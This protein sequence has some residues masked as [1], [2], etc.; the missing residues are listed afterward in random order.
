MQ[1]TWHIGLTGGMGSGKS[2]VANIILAQQKSHVID[3]DAIAHACTHNHGAAI[4]P[5]RK[6]FGNNYIDAQ[7]NMRRDAMRA[8]VFQDK[9]AKNTLESIIHPYVQKH[10]LEQAHT[11][12]QAG[13]TLIVYDL[14]LLVES[15]HWRQRIDQVWVVE[16]DHE[17]Q[18]QRCIQRNP[19]TRTQVEA[20]LKQQA[21][22]A[23]RRNIA[24]AVI[25]NDNHTN[26]Q[27]LTHRTHTLIDSFGGIMHTGRKT[28]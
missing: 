10:I 2:T 28:Q 27:Q 11:A 15:A 20:I 18:V 23:E 14:P 13:A 6:A 5:I 9:Q 26:I 19:L 22:H 12:E 7:G 24:D 21:S 4:E 25:M 8:L 3:A 16:C 17:T 1:T